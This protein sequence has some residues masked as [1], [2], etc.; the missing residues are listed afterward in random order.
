MSQKGKEGREVRGREVD[1]EKKR[2]EKSWQLQRGTRESL[3]DDDDDD[4][5]DAAYY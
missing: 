2:G 3:R 4:V 1:D 5:D